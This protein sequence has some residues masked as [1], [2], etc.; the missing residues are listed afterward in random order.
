MTLRMA[1]LV[2][3]DHENDKFSDGKNSS[4]SIDINFADCAKY[5]DVTRRH[6]EIM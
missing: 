3:N 2:G 5:N 4:N 1:V 6:P